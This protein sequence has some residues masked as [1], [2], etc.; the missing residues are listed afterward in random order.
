MQKH[1][2][3]VPEFQPRLLKKIHKLIKLLFYVVLKRAVVDNVVLLLKNETELLSKIQTLA[4]LSLS[5]Y[6]TSALI[7]LIPEQF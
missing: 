3:R 7:S 5:D 2:N 4:V 1:S 6:E